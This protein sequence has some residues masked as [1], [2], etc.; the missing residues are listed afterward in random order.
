LKLKS[1]KAG[2][3]AAVCGQTAGGSFC[4]VL[5]ERKGGKVASRS[6]EGASIFSDTPRENGFQVPSPKFQVKG[7]IETWNLGLGT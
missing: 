7:A 6:G 1:T 5:D 3:V 2:S 4:I